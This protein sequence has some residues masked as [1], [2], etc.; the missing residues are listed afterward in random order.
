MRPLLQSNE[1][2]RVSHVLRC[3]AARS[4]LKRNL[5]VRAEHPEGVA[6]RLRVEDAV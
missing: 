4:N 2:V 6:P 5:N 1:P 3:G